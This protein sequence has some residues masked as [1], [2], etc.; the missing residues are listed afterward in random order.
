M[1]SFQEIRIPSAEGR[2]V[3]IDRYPARV[4]K[5]SR[6]VVLCHGYTAFRKYS[7]FPWLAKEFVDAGLTAVVVEFS[8]SGD[9]D[10]AGVITDLETFGRST[11][12]REFADVE[13]V[14][15]HCTKEFGAG[16]LGVLGHSRGGTAALHAAA[17]SEE[18]KAAATW[19][20]MSSLS[21]E[22]FG[23]TPE[24]RKLWKERGIFP[25][26]IVR[27]GQ[28]AP[29]QLEV[30]EELD[31]MQEVISELA[32]RV[33]QPVFVCHAEQDQTIP[34][35]DSYD[36]HSWLQH[37]EHLVVPGCD[38]LFNVSHP[39]TGPSAELKAAASQTI[40]FFLKQL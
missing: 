37:S 34:V 33:P 31:R 7:F 28:E 17:H 5:N 26:P 19:C 21:A 2:S 22:R 15:Q 18:V 11:F 8:H 6:C 20:T 25:Y 9:P 39:F 3:V 23:V 36:L 24:V 29:L 27:S 13:A 40:D 14:V 16:P 12:Q 38:H 30:L 4:Q 32:K 1:E 35:Q 10:P